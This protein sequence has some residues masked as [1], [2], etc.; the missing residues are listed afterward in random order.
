MVHSIPRL[1]DRARLSCREDDA[2]YVA[3]IENWGYFDGASVLFDDGIRQRQSDTE[4]IAG[5]ASVYSVKRI[6]DV[7]Q[8]VWRNPFSPIFDFNLH[9]IVPLF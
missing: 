4:P 5:P 8:F 1:L 6:K 7:F 3:D 2:E 9:R